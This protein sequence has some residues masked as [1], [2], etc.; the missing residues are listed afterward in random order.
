MAGHLHHDVEHLALDHDGEQRLQVGRLG[1]GERAVQAL[2]GD[3]GLDRADEAG[4][5]ARGAQRGLDQVAGRG[6]A[7][8]AGD[9]PDGELRGRVAVDAGGQQA[10]HPA[11]VR[12][13][14]HRHAGVAQRGPF[15]AGLVGEDGGGTRGQRALDEV[16]SVRPRARQGGE[17]VSGDHVLGAQRRAAHPHVGVGGRGQVRVDHRGELGHGDRLDAGR[18]RR[19]G[20]D[21][22]LELGRHARKATG[23][24][25]VSDRRLRVRGMIRQDRTLRPSGGP[26][27]TRL[28]PDRKQRRRAPC[29]PTAAR[30]AST[31]NPGTTALRTC[32]PPVGL[33]PA[34]RSSRCPDR[35]ADRR[36]GEI[37][38]RPP[39]PGRPSSPHI[40]LAG[41]RITSRVTA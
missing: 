11:R 3:A 13:H 8:R 34:H 29:P 7:G 41:T 4:A 35:T 17:Q 14:Q 37:R 20:R 27:W 38:S 26:R 30:S 16:G 9:A 1:G 28:R 5:V 6:L 31:D 19:G 10:E 25:S 12:V 36:I 39:T 23:A 15:G 22:A 21:L 18:A 32:D 33:H 2:T 24:R 40:P